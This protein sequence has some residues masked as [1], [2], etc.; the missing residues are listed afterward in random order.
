MYAP[1][2][3][4]MNI[5]DIWARLNLNVQ[6]TPADSDSLDWIIIPERFVVSVENIWTGW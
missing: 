1:V 6:L 5:Q 3:T 4:F 2:G